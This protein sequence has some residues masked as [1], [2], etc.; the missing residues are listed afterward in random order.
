MHADAHQPAV[1]W[2]DSLQQDCPRWL[3]FRRLG[4]VVKRVRDSATAMQSRASFG[5][6]W[7]PPV[8]PKRLVDPEMALRAQ[9]WARCLSIT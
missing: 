5:L 4:R 2:R 3:S 6:P 8:A 7:L 1:S 9:L